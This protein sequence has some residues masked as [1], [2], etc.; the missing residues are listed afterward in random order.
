MT[1]LI[2]GKD[3]GGC[4]TQQRYSW[5][6]GVSIAG[7]LFSLQRA[8]VLLDQVSDLYNDDIII[9]ILE[10]GHRSNKAANL[11]VDVRLETRASKLMLHRLNLIG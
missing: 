3:V 7:P 10:F 2:W 4:D 6:Q 9:V 11:G 8:A 5:C 1:K